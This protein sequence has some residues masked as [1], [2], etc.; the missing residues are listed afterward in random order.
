[1][2]TWRLVAMVLNLLYSSDFLSIY[3]Y[4]RA[5]YSSPSLHLSPCNLST[6]ETTCVSTEPP[7]SEVG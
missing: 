3:Y 1:M 6:E 7:T 2:C 4:F 5:Y